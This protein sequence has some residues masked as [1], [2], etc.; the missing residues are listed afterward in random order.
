MSG[1]MHFVV[2]NCRFENWGGSAID[3]VGC[4]RGVI[5]DSRFI[6]REGSRTKNAI[7]IKGGSNKI[8]VQTSFF[9]DAGERVVNLGGSTGLDYFRP[10]NAPYEAAGVVVAGN[11]FVGGEAQFLG[12]TSYESH[13]HHNLSICRRN[14]WAASSRKRKTRDSTP[15]KWVFSRKI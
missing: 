7:Q 14:G 3:L 15:A 10:P 5:E 9:Q 8:L 13:I 1:V 11:R 12:S 2:R 6:G 4:H